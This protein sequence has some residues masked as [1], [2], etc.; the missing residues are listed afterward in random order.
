VCGACACGL[1]AWCVSLWGC[2]GILVFLF[3]LVNAMIHSSPAYSCVCWGGSGC[4]LYASTR[5]SFSFAYKQLLLQHSKLKL[6]YLTSHK[7]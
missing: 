6:K 4:N 7:S 3:L 2:F 5:F 1:Q